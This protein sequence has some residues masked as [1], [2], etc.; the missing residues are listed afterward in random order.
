MAKKAKKDS[1]KNRLLVKAP[2]DKKHSRLVDEK[3]M[4]S[5]NFLKRT[6]ITH[7]EF[8]DL[9]EKKKGSGIYRLKGRPFGYS[10]ILKLVLKRQETNELTSLWS[11]GLWDIIQTDL[12]DGM[13][14]GVE[15]TLVR[16]FERMDNEA[17]KRSL[18]REEL[19]SRVTT[20]NKSSSIRNYGVSAIHRQNLLESVRSGDGVFN[21]IAE[22]HIF[23]PSLGALEDAVEAL[24]NN[25]KMNDELRN[26]SFEVDS[27][28]QNKPLMTYGPNDAAKNKHLYTRMSS[29]DAAKSSLLVDRGG[30]R[31][32]GS[33][34]L[35]LS[36]GRLIHGAAAYPLKNREMFILGDNQNINAQTI[37]FDRRSRQVWG[38]DYQGY[39]SKVVSRTYLSDGQNVR[40]MVF[41]NKRDV[42]IGHNLMQMPLA[43]N[44]KVFVNASEGKLNV[45]ETLHRNPDELTPA[46]TLA[47]FN[48]HLS[49][50]IQLFSQFRDMSGED[51]VKATGPFADATRDILIKFFTEH[52]YYQANPTQNYD[53]LRLFIRHKDFETM[54]ALGQ[55][56][57]SAKAANNEARLQGAY[58]ELNTII[59]QNILLTFPMINVKTDPIIDDLMEAKYGVIDFSESL[60]GS[61]SIDS[62]ST[63]F[64]ALAYINLLLPSL[65]SGDLIVMHGAS[66]IKDVLP[67][68]VKLVK[69]SDSRVDIL[70][71]EKSQ[72]AAMELIKAYDMDPDLI[73]VSLQDNELD[74]ME[75]V[76]GLSDN[77]TSQMKS[78]PASI[79]VKMKKQDFDYIRLY[80]VFETGF[81]GGDQ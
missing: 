17:L 63:N 48:N 68:I 58:E 81:L 37:N 8:Y 59:N 70:F 71:V 23:A 69:A 6:L 13:P 32:P 78:M 14:E 45:L 76:L 46:Q 51:V 12:G 50:L 20:R 22:M 74:E 79:A 67:L 64:L 9:S 25:L 55:Y 73:M 10:T 11:I 16:G 15:M 43:D 18:G 35:G 42:P 40:H 31:K 66:K 34:F 33:D 36:V 61:S 56:L 30:V 75:S 72:E 39:L 2:R 29:Y 57:F 3:Y 28:Y 62:P 1:K 54:E 7:S 27:D 77:F 24:Q 5:H 49:H 80:S 38:D 19:K 53:D 41:D 52:R 44:E 26:L 60:V 47:F 65:I 4:R 21:F